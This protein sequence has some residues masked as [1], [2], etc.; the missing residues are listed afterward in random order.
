MKLVF[1]LLFGLLSLSLNAQIVTG[2]VVQKVVKADTLHVCEMKQV[3]VECRL[4]SIVVE[5]TNGYTSKEWRGGQLCEVYYPPK[6][7]KLAICIPIYQWREVCNFT[8]R[9]Q[10]VKEYWGDC[11]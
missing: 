4:D 6:V 5:S 10:D 3:V 9:G 1:I 11:P 8:I 7:R 2:C